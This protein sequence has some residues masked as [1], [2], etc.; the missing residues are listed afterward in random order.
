MRTATWTPRIAHRLVSAP[1]LRLLRAEATGRAHIPMRGGLLLAAN[2]RSILDPFLMGA[3]C[4]RQPYFLG[5]TELGHGPF[6]WLNRAAGMV[7][8]RRGRADRQA[9]DEIARLLSSGAVV[10]VFPEGSRSATGELYQF[11]SG[12][13]R[14]AAAARVPV[15]P[16]GLIGTGQYWP[17]GR[18]L[19]AARPPAGLLAVHF[20]TPLDP[21]DE[22]PASRRAFTALLRHR[23]AELSGNPPLADRFLPVD[24]A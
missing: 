14:L 23:V 11:R 5:K 12:V 19:P 16:V 10:G 18:T 13:A 2:H 1:L 9:L 6:G 22:E 7:P 8:V 17:R 4:P 21:P 24:A 3:A 20:G 15:V